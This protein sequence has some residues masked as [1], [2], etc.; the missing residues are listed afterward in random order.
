MHKAILFIKDSDAFHSISMR[1][2]LADRV[3][4]PICHAPITFMMIKRKWLNVI[5]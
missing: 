4:N 1:K 5:R 2:M 3:V